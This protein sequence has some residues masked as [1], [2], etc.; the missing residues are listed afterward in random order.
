MQA[1]QTDQL[2]GKRLG[3]YQ[4][5]HL[6]GH[7]QL[8]AVYM[9]R[10]GAQGRVVLMTIFHYP[11]AISAQE[12]KQ[13]SSNFVR[14]GA[15]LVRL[16][17]PHILPTVDF[18]EQ[19]GYPY[20]VTAFARGASLAQL[21]KQQTRLTPEQALGILRQ[22]AD[23]LDYAHSN[24]VTHGI[25]SLSNVLVGEKLVVQMAG[26]GLK[27]MLDVHLSRHSNHPQAHLL[28]AAGSFLGSPD[29]IAP[30]RVK[31]LPTDARADIYA[32]GIMLYE[33]LS[34][35]PPFHGATPLETA[36]QRVQRPAPLLHA[37]C[38]DLSEG[39]D[40]VIGKALALDPARRYKRAGE[41]AMAF[42]RVLKVL[43]VAQSVVP[44]AP[45]APRRTVQDPQITLPTT[46]NWFDEDARPSGKWQLMPPIITGQLP[47]ISATASSDTEQRQGVYAA[48]EQSVSPPQTLPDTGQPAAIPPARLEQADQAR[49]AAHRADSLVAMDPFAW[50]SSATAKA[51]QPEPGTFAGNQQ[52]PPV[53][54]ARTRGPRQAVNQD[55]RQ[56]VKL[57]ATGAAVAGIFAVGGITFDRFVQSL[58]Q[59]QQ[60]AGAPSSGSTTTT[61]GNTPATGATP[62]P[63]QSPTAAK[64]ATPKPSPTHAAQPTPTA[65]PTQ[66]PSPQPTSQP[67]PQ[68]TQPPPP[69]PTPSPP[70]GHTGT[71]IGNTGQPTNSAVSFTNPADGQSG[72]LIH[73]SNGNFVACEKACTH[74]GVPVYYSGGQQQLVCPAHGAI[75]DP[76]NGFAH[77]SGPGNGP[78][79]TVTIRVNADGTITTG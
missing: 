51:S 43:H 59:P 32:L 21:L 16:R 28:S 49:R 60:F 9:A 45:S 17:H 6:L 36:L 20:L 35:V 14:E 8:S 18:G 67:S 72:L 64:T 55:R 40:L 68:P 62:A 30:E 23:G 37:A 56:V 42:E 25:L 54:L 15:A 5:E 75:F 52:R 4:V 47:G 12:R 71:V 39:F 11:E 10:Q 26:F 13:L 41:V 76:L 74:A 73:L 1:A 31:G 65:K 48:Q 44:S 57:I 3:A 27:T 38:P 79:R 61:Q 58:K 63:Q 69:P 70:P 22:L 33:L 66:Q 19:S 7:G 77:I 29:Y 78:L 46:I 2:V 24:N 53:R 34:G 50:W